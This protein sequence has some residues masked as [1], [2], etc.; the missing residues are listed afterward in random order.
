MFYFLSP[1]SGDGTLQFQNCCNISCSANI[2]TA[3][4]TSSANIVGNSTRSTQSSLIN[5]IVQ[6]VCFFTIISRTS[7]VVM[8]TQSLST[9]DSMQHPSI[10]IWWLQ[11]QPTHWH[12]A[13]TTHFCH[14]IG[15]RHPGR[16]WD[17]YL[18]LLSSSQITATYL[19]IQQ[20]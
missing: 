20:P 7:A 16:H 10:Y 11:I 2:L 12:Q 1:A 4:D 9:P 14:G 3:G 19:K 17:Y 8:F 6:F 5:N 15:A 13:I 18:G